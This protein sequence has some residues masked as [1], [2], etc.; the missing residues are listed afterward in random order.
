MK[1]TPS[2]GLGLGRSHENTPSNN[3]K[4]NI[5]RFCNRAENPYWQAFCGYDYLQWELPVD[6][7]S[8]TRWRKRL[9][10]E[11]MKK[12]LSC[13]IQTAVEAVITRRK[14]AKNLSGSVDQRH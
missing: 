13:T 2:E 3:I 9:G 7:S 11:G 1:M 8:M 4:S 10:E 5:A 14:E 12:I 6:D